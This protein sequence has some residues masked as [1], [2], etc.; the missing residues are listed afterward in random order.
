M[1]SPR[2]NPIAG[3]ATPANIHP[4]LSNMDN[5]NELS[6]A[7]PAEPL[8][9]ANVASVSLSLSV[10]IYSLTIFQ[11]SAT[12]K[13][14]IV[15]VTLE[16]LRKKVNNSED[17]EGKALLANHFSLRQGNAV[18]TDPVIPGINYVFEFTVKDEHWEVYKALLAQYPDIVELDKMQAGRMFKEWVDM[19]RPDQ[20]VDLMQILRCLVDEYVS[21]R[22][23]FNGE[24]VEPQTEGSEISEMSSEVGDPLDLQ[25]A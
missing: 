1:S 14:Y 21:G 4:L 15:T 2:N 24:R 7:L 17:V 12:K 5:I 20:K 25:T 11:G 22:E 8:T 13:Q 23:G 19:G 9:Y 16:M 6:T 10:S 3:A 18:V